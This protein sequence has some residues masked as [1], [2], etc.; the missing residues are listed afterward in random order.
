M[1][2]D[3]SYSPGSCRWTDLNKVLKIKSE[4]IEKAYKFAKQAHLGQKRK[5]GE[6]YL[7]HPVWVARITAE[8]GLD[9]E[10]V[11]AALLHDTVEDTKVTLEDIAK[12]FGDEVA[13]IV[14]GLTEVK[15]KSKMISLHNERIDVFKK[16][17]FASVNDVRVLIIR[18][19]DKLHNGLTIGALSREKQINY[20]NRVFGIYGPIAEYVGL[21]FFKRKLED[22]AFKIQ[23]PEKAKE[24]ELWLKNRSAYE[25]KSLKIISQEIR[26]TLLVNKITD[27]KVEGR[28]KGLYSTYLK[29]Q[30][31]GQDRV[32]DRIGIR[33]IT[34]NIEDCYTVLGLLHAR[35]QFVEDE[36]DDYI[37]NPRP[38]GY[39]SI[40]TTIIG[41]NGITIEIQI[42]TKEMHDYNEFGPA[43]HIAYKLGQNRKKADG[44]GYEW[45]RDL[46]RWQRTK[47]ANNYKLKLLTD[48][49][50]VFTPKGDTIQLPK[51]ST[52][53]DFAYRIHGFVGN[54]C[55]GVKVNGKMGKIDQILKTGD[56]VEIL[57]GKKINVS[58]EWLRIVKTINAREAI[59]QVIRSET[60]L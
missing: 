31:K 34:K 29:I 32:K 33:V 27:F 8:L 30:N 46:V 6:E 3:I 58:Q 13:L 38:N 40:Q 1:E 39:R 52:S 18:L 42:R 11:V 35:Y 36:F 22:I 54:H 50:Y 45:V 5:S 7:N 23:E 26:Q 15:S 55:Y 21:H 10:A 51:G 2:L 60:S 48:F 59:R 49:V 25:R 20:A 12:E 28:I 43:S 19:I 16:F 57:T 24:L 37:A 9:T 56:L 4:K 14:D 47:N 17:L 44:L 41:E 53:L